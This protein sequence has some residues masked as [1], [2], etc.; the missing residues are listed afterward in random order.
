MANAQQ[1]YIILQRLLLLRLS[2]F[3]KVLIYCLLQHRW[4][5]LLATTLHVLCVCKVCRTITRVQNYRKS[6]PEYSMLFAIVFLGNCW[7]FNWGFKNAT[8]LRAALISSYK[9]SHKIKTAQ[10]KAQRSKKAIFAIRANDTLRSSQSTSCLG[11][12]GQSDS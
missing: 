4:Q 12:Q 7:I 11:F 10:R 6:T 2:L 9:T 3:L 8:N 1:N 5:S